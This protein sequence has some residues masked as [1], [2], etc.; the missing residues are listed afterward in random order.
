MTGWNVNND[1]SILTFNDAAGVHVIR[2]VLLIGEIVTCNKESVFD[3]TI[4]VADRQEVLGREANSVFA[5]VLTQT[6]WAQG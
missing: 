3:G 2:H 4:A 6:R 5:P 1:G